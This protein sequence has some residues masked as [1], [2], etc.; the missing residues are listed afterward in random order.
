MLGCIWT[1][2]IGK[3]TYEIEV[4]KLANQCRNDCLEWVMIPN[5]FSD[6]SDVEE[7]CGVL[8]LASVRTGNRLRIW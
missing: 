8:H 4:R 2:D 1:P 7:S 3:I 6:S 5:I